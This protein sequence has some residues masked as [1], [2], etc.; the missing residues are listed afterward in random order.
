MKT[1]IRPVDV[2]KIRD[3]IMNL[4]VFYYRFKWDPSDF[5]RVGTIT[6]PDWAVA[7]RDFIDPVSLIFGLL[8]VVQEQQK[9]IEGLKQKCL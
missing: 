6:C 9:D 2:T 1:D 7:S 4:P 3:E 8:A 5:I